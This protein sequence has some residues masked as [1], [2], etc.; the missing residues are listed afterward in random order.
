MAQID[1]L[2]TA[3]Q[4]ED[5]D[6]QQIAA[7]ATKVDAD[8]V[9]LLAKIQAGNIPTDLTT[10]IQAIQAHTAALATALGQLNDADT[11]ANPP[12]STPPS[13]S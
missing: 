9:A 13:G 1:D 3:I 11:Q 10:Q 12:A 5:V 8:V 4:A 6:V 2:N 7:V